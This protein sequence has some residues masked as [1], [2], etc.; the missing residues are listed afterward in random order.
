[1][2]IEKIDIFP[3]MDRLKINLNIDKNLKNDKKKEKDG[4]INNNEAIQNIN[5]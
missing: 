4:N 2:R 3:L 5:I 1:M